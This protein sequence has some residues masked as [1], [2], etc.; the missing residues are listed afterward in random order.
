[1]GDAARVFGH[2]QDGA[3]IL[4][5]LVG[6][7][8]AVGGLQVVGVVVAPVGLAGGLGGGHRLFGHEVVR[9]GGLAVEAV[10][11]RER[12]LLTLVGG[13]RR[14]GLLAHEVGLVGSA[15]LERPGQHHQ[16]LLLVLGPE[17]LCHLGHEVGLVV[18][19]ALERDLGVGWSPSYAPPRAS[20]SG[21]A[22][23]GVSRS[24]DGSRCWPRLRTASLWAALTRAFLCGARLGACDSRLHTR[25]LS[26]G[27]RLGLSAGSGG[28]RTCRS[29]TRTASRTFIA[30][31]TAPCKYPLLTMKSGNKKYGNAFDKII[32]NHSRLLFFVDSLDKYDGQ[33]NSFVFLWS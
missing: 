32:E 26:R 24:C 1:M 17:R 20:C 12:H 7:F 29:G 11:W 16:L 28:C 6:E 3:D 27:A 10:A 31:L 9:V 15:A 14:P 21:L 4:E 19:C 30:C 22:P 23:A 13:P 8:L 2:L 5:T 33:K 25:L 18:S